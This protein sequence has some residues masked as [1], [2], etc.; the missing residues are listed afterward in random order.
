[1]DLE[2]RFVT[3]TLEEQRV[4]VVHVSLIFSNELTLQILDLFKKISVLVYIHVCVHVCVC[5]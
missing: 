4:E 2:S 5:I 1:M 3:G